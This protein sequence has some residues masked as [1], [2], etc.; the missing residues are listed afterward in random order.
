MS[1]ERSFLELSA[2][3]LDALTSGMKLSSIL[4]QTKYAMV[5]ES[6]KREIIIIKEAFVLLDPKRR[7]VGVFTRSDKDHGTK[8]G[9]C[10]TL[11]CGNFDKRECTVTRDGTI[12]YDVKDR[13]HSYVREI[14]GLF[15]EVPKAKIPT[16]YYHDQDRDKRY[17]FLLFE[18][19]C[20]S[21]HMPLC[22]HLD[23]RA[24]DL[25]I[26]MRDI[27][28]VSRGVEKYNRS[29]FNVDKALVNI[30][31]PKRWSIG[32]KFSLAEKLVEAKLASFTLIKFNLF[33][34]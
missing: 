3:P 9:E 22:Y 26:G 2:L 1:K 20:S 30:L 28:D 19:T 15:V 8:I 34:L 6:E 25:F 31:A 5:S 29:P 13:L 11:L 12:I 18:L 24:E 23:N 4:E 21:E 17:L 33:G 32:G 16:V 10:S 14:S 7:R 27:R